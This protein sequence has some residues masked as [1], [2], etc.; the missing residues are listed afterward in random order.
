MSG[1]AF[2]A[3]KPV[4]KPQTQP[5]LEETGSKDAIVKKTG[6]KDGAQENS[7][8]NTE[9]STSLNLLRKEVKN[10]L[11]EMNSRLKLVAQAKARGSKQPVE[12]KEKDTG[13]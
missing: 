11:G 6:E 12:E 7:E 1:Q 4:E 5:K 3:P 13:S 9:I 10:G 2:V 8:A